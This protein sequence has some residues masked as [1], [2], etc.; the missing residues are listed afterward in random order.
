M[1][2]MLAKLMTFWMPIPK[3][4]KKVLVIK[5]RSWLFRRGLRKTVKFGRDIRIEKKCVFTRGSEV[6]DC[7]KLAGIHVYGK[8]KIKIG[9][10][11]QLSWNLRVH[12]SNHDYQGDML[13]FGSGNTVKDVEIGDCVW[14]G[15][16]VLL[17]PGTKIGEGSIIQGGSVVHGEIP[18]YAIAGGNPAKVFAQRD[19]EHFNRLKAAGKFH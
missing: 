6:G 17:L 2:R 10:H 8:G 14:I 16:D 12:T 3:S 5:L 9:A 1:E 15:S 7:T 18:P 4:R 13:P 11:C 19:V